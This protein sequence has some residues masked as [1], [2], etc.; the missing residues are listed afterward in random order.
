MELVLQCIIVGLV[1]I[2]I[3]IFCTILFF[4]LDKSWKQ[5]LLGFGGFIT[6]GGIWK[7]IE[8][9]LSIPQK[10]MTV[11]LLVLLLSM[12]ISV[13]FTFKK[14]CTILK[15]QTGENVIRIL[16]IIL[17]YDDFLKDYYESRKRNI[18]GM[19]RAEE[20][21]KKKIALDN[22]EKYL[23][24]LKQNIE[25]QKGESLILELPENSEYPITKRFVYE[26]PYFVKHIS[27]FENDLDRLTEDFLDIFT[28]DKEYNAECL[29]GYFAGIGM[30]IANDLFG[31][32]NE[33]VR[34]HF[35]ILKDNQYVQYSVVV[36]QRISD[37]KI[38]DIPKDDSGTIG[39]SF[40]LKKSLVASLNRESTYD[41][42]TK[43]EDYMTIT[44]YN[45]LYG[46]YPFLSMG[47]S[48]KYSEQFG[49]MLYFLNFYKIEDTLQMFMNRINKVC[50]IVETLKEM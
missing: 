13:F 44:Y 5:I 15:Q 33:D 14:L 8:L 9:N 29:K 42:K 34:T 47:I 45:F 21:E 16:D 6:T 41:T 39:K 7:A 3:G 37:D 20:L 46:E 24:N 40:E 1:G 35:R 36:G 11:V 10:N 25:E 27:Q 48:I 12:M 38:T 26:I 4:R 28:E 50:N 18:D 17:G 23:L 19:V 43:W 2:I 30:Y 32:S 22:Q 49:D 31:T